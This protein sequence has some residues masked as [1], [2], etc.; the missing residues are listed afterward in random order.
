MEPSSFKLNLDNGLDLN[1][2]VLTYI[3]TPYIMLQHNIKLE[4]NPSKSRTYQ[5]SSLQDLHAYVC[6][7][8]PAGILLAQSQRRSN[9][10]SNSDSDSLV[11]VQVVFY[12]ILFTKSL[13]KPTRLVHSYGFLEL[14]CPAS[15]KV[16]RKAQDHKLK[17]DRRLPLF[18]RALS[19]ATPLSHVSSMGLSG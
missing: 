12:F 14:S 18:A 11:R 9:S 1:L 10:D 15:P 3:T 6:S 7:E 17:R 2:K 5:Q 19:I 4:L 8:P 16:R 13:R